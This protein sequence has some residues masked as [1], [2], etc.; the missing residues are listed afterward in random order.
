[1]L[2][3]RA[4]SPFDLI[5]IYRYLFF[6]FGHRQKGFR[7]SFQS[8]NP[9]RTFPARIVCHLLP[10]FLFPPRIP[11]LSLSPSSF[12]HLIRNPKVPQALNICSSNCVSFSFSR[13]ACFTR[14]SCR[15]WMVNFL[16]NLL[17]S[18]S[19]NSLFLIFHSPY[20]NYHP[21]YIPSDEARNPNSK[22]CSESLMDFP[23]LL[24]W[25][26][27]SFFLFPA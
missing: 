10:L 26:L 6:F 27:S 1:M 5:S 25:F 13:Q 24:D 12:Y 11:V 3:R 15:R 9:P 17:R 16:S 20:E 23:P 8:V 19:G 14:Y 7:F 22:S 4:F 2:P 18:R 21:R